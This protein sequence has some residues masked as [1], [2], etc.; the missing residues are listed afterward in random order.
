MSIEI[1][2]W[3]T[4]RSVTFPPCLSISFL[5]ML[6]IVDISHFQISPSNLLRGTGYR[7]DI[8][9]DNIIMVQGDGH[10]LGIFEG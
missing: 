2:C 7:K 4:S 8:E 10:A 6:N 3:S 1:T 9:R 5:L